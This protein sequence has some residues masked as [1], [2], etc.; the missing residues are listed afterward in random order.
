MSTYTQQTSARL[1][2]D[3]SQLVCSPNERQGKQRGEW[4][5]ELEQT[6]PKDETCRR[7]NVNTTVN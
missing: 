4:E 6:D 2:D 3:Q 7:A 1:E 5:R